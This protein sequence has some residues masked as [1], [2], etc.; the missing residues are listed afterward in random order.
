MSTL[1]ERIA[2]VMTKTGLSV[3][4]IATIAQV[5]SSAVTQWKDGPTQTIKTAPATR[6]AERTGFSALWLATGQ[7]AMLIPAIQTPAVKFSGV[8]PLELV[9]GGVPTLEQ[10]LGVVL[11]ALA[12]SP[13]QAEIKQLLPMLIDT[14]AAAYRARLL[15]LLAQ[16]AAP[17]M[18]AAES[19]DFQPPVPA[20]LFNKPKQPT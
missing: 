10:A 18:P 6:L 19:K 9:G 12:N 16:P 15:E 8:D 2:E 20:T 4:E 11:D 14:N 3:G 7:G 17:P 13:A 1:Q 5:S